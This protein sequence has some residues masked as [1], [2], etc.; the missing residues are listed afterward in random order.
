MK[1]IDPGHKYKVDG[2]DGRKKQTITFMKREGTGYP[3]NEG[4][5][6]G[7]NCQELIRVVFDRTNYLNKQH[8]HINNLAIIRKLGEIMWLFE[9]RAA[10]RHGIDQFDF[11]PGDIMNA[12]PC[13]VYGHV[14]C[15][16]H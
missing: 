6:P 11:R 15:K 13:E 5:Y 1:I 7:T 10:Q 3:G 9:D 8:M 4:S 2:Y 16:G 12:N 14:I